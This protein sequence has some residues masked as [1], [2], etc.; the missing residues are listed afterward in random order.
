VK[1]VRAPDGHVVRDVT[2][3]VTL[4]GA[5]DRA[6]TA[7]DNAA[8]VA[9]D[10]MKNTVYAL[11]KDGLTA[12]IED[13][14]LALAEH[15]CAELAVERATI[16]L[17]EHHWTRLR[18]GENAF[19]RDGEM[20]RTAS[21][22]LGSGERSV[23]AGVADLV[24]MKT[25]GSSFT[26][27]P[28]DRFTTLREAD[29]RIMATRLTGSWRYADQ[30]DDHEVLFA[31]VIE[32]LLDVFAA[33]TSRSVQETIWI[34]GRAILERHDEVVEVHLSLPNLHHWIVDLSP[35]GLDNDGEIFVATSEPFGSIEASVRRGR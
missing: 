4:Q 17:R 32:T 18:P 22:S 20:T 7:G 5:F 25:E 12:S 26:G 33:H 9:T 30:A 8:V 13:F 1:L 29:D 11:A 31:S 6:Y 10:T 16:D 35:F 34:V 19:R 3:A 15:F 23:R 28:R 21:V 27:F 2:V 14:G 24:L